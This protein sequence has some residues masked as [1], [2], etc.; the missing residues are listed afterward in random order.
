MELT[1]YYVAT[2]DS[3][4]TVDAANVSDAFDEAIE[5]IV[6]DQKRDRAMGQ[7]TVASTQGFDSDSGDDVFTSTIAVMERIGFKKNEDGEM[8]R[9]KTCRGVGR[10]DCCEET[11]CLDCGGLFT[12]DC[13]DC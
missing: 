6:N 3:R 5:R 12:R 9:C 8:V 4:V 2:G 7:I 10:L 1:R 13:P 11:D